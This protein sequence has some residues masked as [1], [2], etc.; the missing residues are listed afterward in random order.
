MAFFLAAFPNHNTNMSTLLAWAEDVMYLD[1][2]MKIRLSVAA[3]NKPK[4]ITSL[5]MFASLLGNVAL[6]A[7][8]TKKQKK[9]FTM[10]NTSSNQNKIFTR[11]LKRKTAVSVHVQPGLLQFGWCRLKYSCQ[12]SMLDRMM[13]YLREAAGPCG[14]REGTYRLRTSSLPCQQS[15]MCY[16][17]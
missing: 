3:N 16:L 15:C 7:K 2:S 1:T 9:L 8:K 6:A 4:Q 13:N 12:S 14:C 17:S 10:T 11:A 5:S